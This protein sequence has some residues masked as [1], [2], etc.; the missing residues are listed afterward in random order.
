MKD[1]TKCPNCHKRNFSI[2]G[3]VHQTGFEV[4]TNP[5]FDPNCNLIKCK[6][7]KL[8]WKDPF[9]NQTGLSKD[10]QINAIF[11]YIFDYNF[12]HVIFWKFYSLEMIREYDLIRSY[13]NHGLVLDIGAGTGEF[14]SKFPSKH[15]NRYIFDPYLS[16]SHVKT[17][18]KKI[19]PHVN[20]FKRLENYPSGIFDVVILRDVV[21]H[22]AEFPNIFRQVHRLLNKNGI[23]YIKTPNID[24]IDF[25]TFQLSWYLIRII[26]HIIFFEKKT[27]ADILKKNGFKIELNKPINY[28]TVMSLFRSVSSGYP[29]PLRLIASFIYF[30]ISPL[31][32]EGTDFMIIA[33]K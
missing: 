24:S 31:L 33:R 19:S 4:E 1:K 21:E 32:G 11:H 13:K 26:H 3:V 10:Y 8:I 27:L 30:L 14:L 16:S 12:F 15:W 29:I 28:F 18:R 23:L 22:T 2:L 17:L 9:P 6:Y 7:C 25:K 5:N 20:E